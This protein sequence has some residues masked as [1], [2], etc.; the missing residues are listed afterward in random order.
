MYA[1]YLY[2]LGLSF[3]NAA[4]AIEPFDK[5]SHVAIWEWVQRFSPA[6]RR[7][8]VAAYLIDETMVQVGHE[9]AWLWVAVEPVHMSVLGVYVSRHRNILVAE[10]FLRS[11]IR[12]YGRHVVYSDAGPW[13]PDACRSLGLE[14][15][16]HSPFEKSIIER[17]MEYVKDRTECFDDYYPCTRQE[18]SL[19]HVYR[20]LGLFVSMHNA[21][22]PSSYKLDDGG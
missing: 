4:R 2:F 1:L 15:R 6:Y 19:S 9:Q 7:T 8:R 14:H 13:Y 20:W 10:T 11:L 12:L 22:R 21:T 18:C 16:L 17:M 3:R 5:R